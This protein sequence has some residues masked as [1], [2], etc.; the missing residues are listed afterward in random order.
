MSDIVRLE[1]YRRPLERDG[2]PTIIKI[3][4]GETIECIDIDALSSNQLEK[5]LGPN[6]D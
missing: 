1:D 6:K 5:Y 4:E 3:V 2:Y